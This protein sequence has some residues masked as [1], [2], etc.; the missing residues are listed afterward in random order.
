MKILIL[1]NIYHENDEIGSHDNFNIGNW[2]FNFGTSYIM[3]EKKYEILN[4]NGIKEMDQNNN[5]KKYKPDI[6][7]IPIANN[8]SY[9]QTNINLLKNINNFIKKFNCKKYIFSIGAQNVNNEM[10]KL[11]PE[12][13][14]IVRK[15]FSQMEIINLRG[16]YTHKLLK[17]NKLDYNYT[18]Y[19]CPSI[20]LI[21]NNLK[22]N[23]LTINSKILFNS[24]GDHHPNVDFFK[25]LRS[26]KDID[27]LIQTSVYK[28][29]LGNYFKPE[30]F[31]KWKN[32]VKKYDFVIGTRIHGAIISLVCNIPTLLIVI[33]SRT[34][35]LAE[36]FNIPHIK[37]LDNKLVLK[38]KDDI[39][40]LI[41]NFNF[42]IDLLNNTIEERKK[43]FWNILTN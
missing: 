25:I 15:L 9:H 21:K 41:N 24:P 13:I 2:L 8:I 6:I 11:N 34:N 4:H 1:P 32:I 27:Y 18:V 20:N 29:T 16:K 26:C 35:E 22:Y 40:K 10:F 7:I 38:S 14:S 3:K 23:K 43:L 19:G 12:L 28:N 17:Y 33:D 36:I 37:N 5:Y 30:S 42:N 31:N 39:V